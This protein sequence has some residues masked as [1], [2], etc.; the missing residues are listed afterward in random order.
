MYQ[1]CQR[2]CQTSD[3]KLGFVKG[4]EPQKI[5]KLRNVNLGGQS[6]SG[7]LG[8]SVHKALLLILLIFLIFS[9]I[10]FFNVRKKGKKGRKKQTVD[11]LTSLTLITFLTEMSKGC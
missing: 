10:F 7:V 1:G 11:D 8:Q 3:T 2:G 6:V 4:L 9:N 5:C